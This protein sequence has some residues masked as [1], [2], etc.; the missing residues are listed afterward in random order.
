MIAMHRITDARALVITSCLLA[1]SGIPASAQVDQQRAATYFKEA[2]TLCEREGGRLWGVS[3]CGPM[4][5]ADP[6]TKSIATNQLAPAAPQ[7]AA[8]G[9]ANAAMDWGGV[10]W[11]TFV[12]QMMP[13]DQHARARM[14]L[15]ELFHRIQPQLGFLTR[16]GQN[17]HLDTLDGRYWLQLEWRALARALGASG[18]ERTAAIRDALAFRATRRKVFPDA[19]ENERLE[20]IREGLAQYTGT[21]AAAASS[22]VA[23]ADVINQLAEYEKHPTFVRTFAYPSGAAYGILLDGWSPGWTRRLEPADDMGQLLMAAS[24]VQ[25]GEDADAAAKRYGDVELRSAEEKRDT[26]QK[27]RIAELRRSFVGD[28]VLVLP[29]APGS[30][31]SAGVTPLPGAGTVYP[32]VRVTAEWGVL[33]AA[34]ALR[35]PDRSKLILTTPTKA[36][37]ATLT[38]DGWTLKLAPGWIVS[39]G[40][41]TGDFQIVRGSPPDRGL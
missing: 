25:Q 18:A 10:R 37:G 19:T 29:G 21:V 4:V 5:I 16:D 14:M 6:S 23:A 27:A 40:P 1:G 17:D 22:A 41:R 34:S 28:P 9:F 36:D 8:I 2:A 15:H 7:P 12:W 13:A 20:E 39:P 30:F 3:L 35:S 11:S 32:N 31:S 26:E 33:E 38:G 24:N